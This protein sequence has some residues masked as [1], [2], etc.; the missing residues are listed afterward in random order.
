MGAKVLGGEDDLDWVLPALLPIHW[1]RVYNSRDE[2]RD[3]LFGV[4]W[5]V[6]FEVSVQIE[7]HPEGGERLIYTDEQGRSIDLGL[8]APG[9]AT[10]SAR[11]RPERATPW[12]RPV[13]DRKRRGFIPAV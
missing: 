10:Y 3:G 7:L 9:Q 13:A 2:R 1:Q 6:R 12:Q 8:I 4:G 5:S 11:R